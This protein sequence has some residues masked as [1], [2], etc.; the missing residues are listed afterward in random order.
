MISDK[1]ARTENKVN[2]NVNHYDAKKYV[3]QFKKRNTL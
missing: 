1:S 3:A 2:F